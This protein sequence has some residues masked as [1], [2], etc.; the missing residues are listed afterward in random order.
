MEAARA[1]EW[2]SKVVTTWRDTD[3]VASGQASRLP[4]LRQVLASSAAAPAAVRRGGQDEQIAKVFP[5]LL[6]ADSASHR[7]ISELQDALVPSLHDSIV[8][9]AEQDHEARKRQ[10]T[11]SLGR[12]LSDETQVTFSVPPN[13]RSFHMRFKQCAPPPDPAV[14]QAHARAQSSRRWGCSACS[15]RAARQVRGWRCHG[16][17]VQPADVVRRRLLHAAPQVPGAARGDGAP[18]HPVG[19]VGARQHQRQK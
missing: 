5:H 10:A 1:G 9:G 11:E 19:R 4:N 15:T 2:M 18:C 17:L 12:G 8:R 3:T 16:R 6:P 14:Q 7:P 13:A